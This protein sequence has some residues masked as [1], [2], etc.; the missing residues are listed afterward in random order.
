MENNLRRESVFSFSPQV[1]SEGEERTGVSEQLPARQRRLAPS[2]L[3]GEGWGEGLPS[4]RGERPLTPIASGDAIRPLPQGERW[5]RACGIGP[6][7][8]IAFA[9]TVPLP[10]LSPQ[11]RGEG[12][13]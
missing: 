5:H 7:I 2:P 4:I 3:V 11:A 13:H 1:R 6:S 12:A 9:E 8:D 10:T